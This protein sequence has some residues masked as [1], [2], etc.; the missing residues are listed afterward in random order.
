MKE[1]KG[2]TGQKELSGTGTKTTDSFRRKEIRSVDPKRPPVRINIMG[3]I[4]NDRKLRLSDVG[5]SIRYVKLQT[6]PDTLLLYDL[7]F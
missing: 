7:F 6:P 5:S 1:M 3:T 2:T 4:G